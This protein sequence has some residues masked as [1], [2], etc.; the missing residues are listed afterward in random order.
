[1]GRSKFKSVVRPGA[2][3][4][5]REAATRRTDI[6]M[7]I[8]VATVQSILFKLSAQAATWHEGYSVK[9]IADK[10]YILQIVRGRSPLVV[11][12]IS[13]ERMEG[14]RKPKETLI[15]SFQFPSSIHNL[16]VCGYSACLV[17]TYC[18][19]LSAR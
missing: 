15:E 14:S 1:M 2:V 11:D 18:L 6:T 12:L 5:P 13:F 3:L 7:N 16:S 17:L 10:Q 19:R 9:T 4:P 8:K